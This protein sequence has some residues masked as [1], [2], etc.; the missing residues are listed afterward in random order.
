[1]AVWAMANGCATAVPAPTNSPMSVTQV[2]YRVWT[3]NGEPRGTA[4][5]YRY[6]GEQYPHE[7]WVEFRDRT[8]D[9]EPTRMRLPLDSLS[10]EDITFLQRNCPDGFPR[11]YDRKTT[12]KSEPRPP[13][14]RR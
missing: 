6:G 4:K 12:P 11:D 3:I 9:Q 7:V 1:M 5:F 10:N 2:V 14:Y 8:G 13:G